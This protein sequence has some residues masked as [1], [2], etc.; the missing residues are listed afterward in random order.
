M[1]DQIVITKEIAAK[2][3]GA[4]G[5]DMILSAFAEDVVQILIK[6]NAP[7]AQWLDLEGE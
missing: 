5:K 1:Q 7:G 4:V 2:A 6:L 3:A